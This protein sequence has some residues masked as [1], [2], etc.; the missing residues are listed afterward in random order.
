MFVCLVKSVMEY[1]VEIWRWE[2][3]KELKKLM[4]DYARSVFR[5][6]FC[7]PRYFVR[8]EFAWNEEIKSRMGV[9]GALSRRRLR[10]W[11]T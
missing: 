8:K 10:Q 9:E 2:K 5:I 6:D 7:T 4:L 11:R 3:K 1:G